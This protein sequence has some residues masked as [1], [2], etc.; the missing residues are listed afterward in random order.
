MNTE[1]ETGDKSHVSESAESDLNQAYGEYFNSLRGAYPLP[2]GK[3]PSKSPQQLKSPLKLAMK[4]KKFVNESIINMQ[5]EDNVYN[6]PTKQKGRKS[7]MVQASEL[8]PTELVLY[9]SALQV[10]HNLTAY[11]DWFI[12]A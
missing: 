2:S 8:I 4:C 11:S 3:S 12:R 10:R 5:Q 9:V 6:T 7:K 1:P